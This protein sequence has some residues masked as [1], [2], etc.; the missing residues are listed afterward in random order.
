[1]SLLFRLYEIL[2][3]R[4]VPELP[5]EW[6]RPSGMRK[7][8]F[9]VPLA[10]LIL[11]GMLHLLFPYWHEEP[12]SKYLEPTPYWEFCLFGAGSFAGI[13]WFVF[14]R[15]KRWLDVLF[16]FVS[17]AAFGCL[18]VA[19]L[20][21][22]RPGRIVLVGVAAAAAASWGAI[23]GMRRLLASIRARPARAQDG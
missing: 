12:E 2:K 22:P 18:T 14:V 7:F 3:G 4:P 23:T 1:M 16:L 10:C 13:A 19:Y 11:A 17:H 15:N 5:E 6:K 9:W 21:M 20:A 8:G